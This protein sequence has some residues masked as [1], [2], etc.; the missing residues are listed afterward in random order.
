MTTQNDSPAQAEPGIDTDGAIMTA[1]ADLADALGCSVSARVCAD[2]LE[3]ELAP[4]EGPTG[5]AEH[6]RL[7]LLICSSM[8]QRVRSPDR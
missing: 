3:L 6:S 5:D 8:T 1:G 2:I 7:D 4:F